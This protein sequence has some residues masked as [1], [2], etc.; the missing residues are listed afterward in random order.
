MR[1]RGN[2]AA[3]TSARRDSRFLAPLARPPRRRRPRPRLR[4]R[5][6]RAAAHAARLPVPGLV[7]RR[8]AALEP[9]G[10]GAGAA[11]R[12]ALP[13]HRCRL[14]DPRP[15]QRTQLEARAC[16]RPSTLRPRPQARTA[17][18]TCGR[19]RRARRLAEDASGEVRWKRW[20]PYLSER[21]W[22]TVREDYSA[23]GNAWDYFS[24]RPRPL[25]RLSL[26]RGRP[27][28]HQRRP[29]APLPRAGAVERPRPDPQGAPLRPDQ[30][31]GQPRRGREGALL[32]PRRHADALLPEDALQV[33]AARVS[34]R[35]AG[36]GEPPPRQGRAGVRA[37][38]HRHLRRR[39]LLRRL[40][41]VRQGR[42]PTTS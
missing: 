1:V 15:D 42:R 6:R 13:R 34:L 14:S 17:P 21:Q 5:R 3:A 11:D 18:S 39:P 16:S 24:A 22:G 35:A 8:A 9:P 19:A 20:G 27:R 36:R 25:P 33:S 30:R 4:D 32:L 37:A 31:R 23:D 38:R 40:R 41:R 10:R 26:G 2:S 28:R 7:G 29:A 12:H